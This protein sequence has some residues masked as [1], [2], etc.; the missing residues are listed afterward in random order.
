MHSHVR[1]KSLNNPDGNLRVSVNLCF[2]SRCISCFSLGTCREPEIWIHSYMDP[3]RYQN[4]HRE[5]KEDDIFKASLVS[6]FHF[7]CLNYPNEQEANW[8]LLNPPYI[9]ASNQSW[10]QLQSHEECRK[11]LLLQNPGNLYRSHFHCPLNKK[12]NNNTKKTQIRLDGKRNQ[13]RASPDHRH[14]LFL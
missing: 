3:D 8:I 7:G 10:F 13:V 12:K 14:R 4:Q 1:D 5:E 6:G 11:G 9:E 2:W